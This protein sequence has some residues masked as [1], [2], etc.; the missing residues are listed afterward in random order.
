MAALADPGLIR[1]RRPV[2]LK[3][4]QTSLFTSSNLCLACKIA[5]LAKM[6]Y[7]LR[8]CGATI[9][10]HMSLSLDP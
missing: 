9:N 3:W 6:M 8:V 2:H 7:C 10:V 5:L 4:H 1:V